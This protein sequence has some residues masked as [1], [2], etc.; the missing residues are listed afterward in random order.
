MSQVEERPQASKTSQD[1]QS[2]ENLRLYSYMEDNF[3][4]IFSLLA[5]IMSFSIQNENHI[6]QIMFSLQHPDAQQASAEFDSREYI[7]NLALKSHEK[8]AG[9]SNV[10]T[11]EE[12]IASTIRRKID[13]SLFDKVENNHDE[14]KAETSTDDIKENSSPTTSKGQ[15]SPESAD[16]KAKPRRKRKLNDDNPVVIHCSDCNQ[17][18]R[19]GDGNYTRHLKE[20]KCS[21]HGCS[22]CGKR[23]K[24]KSYLSI[25]MAIH[26]RTTFDEPELKRSRIKDENEEELPTPVDLSVK[27][28]NQGNNSEFFSSLNLFENNRSDEN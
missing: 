15:Q 26:T 27:K 20:M 23:F 12:S 1:R 5:P 24:K 2:V 4:R 7:H 6:R 17:V 21:P 8:V 28:E 16:E 22:V 19:K 10:Q 14:S 9:S 25:H 18:F 13:T 3:T 11:S